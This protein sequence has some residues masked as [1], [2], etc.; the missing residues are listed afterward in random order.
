MEKNGKNI[1]GIVVVLMSIVCVQ[2]KLVGQEKAGVVVYVRV[3]GGRLVTEADDV[4]KTFCP[5]TTNVLVNVGKVLQ[6][7]VRGENTLNHKRNEGKN[8]QPTAKSFL[9]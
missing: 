1:P 6:D 5:V 3:V 2:V 4:V 7:I 8:G 9:R